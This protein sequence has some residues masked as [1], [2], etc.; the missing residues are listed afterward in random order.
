MQLHPMHKRKL[1]SSSR[2]DKDQTDTACAGEMCYH[3]ASVPSGA[4]NCLHLE[5]EIKSNSVLFLT[6]TL[7][8]KG[9]Q[10]R[11]VHSEPFGSTLLYVITQVH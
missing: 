10:T 3:L 9:C 2:Q 11:V 5:T 7:K 1:S 4:L 6:N 8:N